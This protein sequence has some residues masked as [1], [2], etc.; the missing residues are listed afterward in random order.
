MLQEVDLILL[1][2]FCR[3]E[4]RVIWFILLGYTRNYEVAKFVIKRLEIS[5]IIPK[6]FI[7]LH[8]SLPQEGCLEEMLHGDGKA[9]T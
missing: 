8:P 4:K 9:E 2:A 5:G 3:L 7:S 1:Y 6:T